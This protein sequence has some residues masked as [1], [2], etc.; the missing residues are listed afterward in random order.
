MALARVEL[1]RLV[2]LTL[3]LGAGSCAIIFPF[4]FDRWVE[5]LVINSCIALSAVPMLIMLRRGHVRSIGT[6]T[7]IIVV[8][9]VLASVVGSGGLRSPAVLAFPAALMVTGFAASV[10]ATF[11]AVVVMVVSLVL[12]VVAENHGLLEALPRPYSTVEMC[13]SFSA[14]LIA[15]AVVIH[16]S[17][18][19][20]REALDGAERSE[21]RLRDLVEQSPDGIIALTI[22]GRITS[23]NAAAHAIV[24]AA[25]G[26]LVGGKLWAIPSLVTESQEILEAW[27]AHAEEG[28]SVDIG[29]DFDRGFG[30]VVH[31]RARIRRA[32]H[33]ERSVGFLVTLR[34]ETARVRAELERAAL[35]D[36][37]ARTQKMQVVGQLAGGVAHDFNNY[38]TIIRTCTDLLRTKLPGAPAKNIVSL[39]EAISEA[40]VRST[41]L[42]RQLLVFSRKQ[43]M[44]A[45]LVDL[46][47]LVRSTEP[48][49]RRTLDPRIELR[50]SHDD[51]PA[52]AYVDASQFEV[53]L[54]NLVVNARDAMPEGGTLTIEITTVD[55]P[56]EFVTRHPGVPAGRAVMLAVHDTG[57]GMDEETLARAC[58]PFF[59]TKGSHG[60]GLGLSSV[61]GIVEQSQG[62]LVLESVPGSGTSARVFVPFVEGEAEP[63]PREVE[64]QLAGGTEKILL[65]ED[66]PLLRDIT[67]AMLRSHGYDVTAVESSEA[68]LALCPEVLAGIDLLL[69]DVLLPGIDGIALAAKL[70]TTR[71]DLPVLL[72]S[73]YT[74]TR[75]SSPD[76]RGAHIPL[77]SKPYTA[78]ALLEN[79]RGLID[80][81]GARVAS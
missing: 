56:E 41:D 70:H 14:S 47:A 50:V 81:E 38:L 76:G 17:L 15:A 52:T 61:Y 9:A 49:A 55:L 45:R 65:V 20:L 12:I 13:F 32:R 33:T 26:T 75:R 37:V 69:S 34:D 11:V 78:R 19:A 43:V 18:R 21:R 35:Q 54:L 72:V 46:N 59:T 80:R 5:A 44:Q 24:G 39:L 42:T 8:A 73:G 22:D 63:M 36:V 2:L 31:T 40:T 79:I 29:A 77:L 28:D 6:L 7:A 66:L 23:A 57:I 27:V 68:A 58:E 67:A 60:T 4:V 16:V 53:A 25:D 62:T 74:D 3:F 30:E 64:A 51:G 48:M 10:R 1:I 71:P